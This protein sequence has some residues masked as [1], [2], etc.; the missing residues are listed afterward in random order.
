MK[1]LVIA[2]ATL[3]LASA[4]SLA[5]AIAELPDVKDGFR[6]QGMTP[7][8]RSAQPTGAH[9]RAEIVRWR[10]VAEKAGIRPE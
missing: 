9:S 3:L 7:G 5:Q 1:R 2:F 4:P 6:K 8:F 10:N